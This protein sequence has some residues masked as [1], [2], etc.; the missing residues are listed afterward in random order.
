MSNHTHLV[1]FV[2]E[3]TAKAW[4]SSEVIERWHQL[5]KGTLLTQQFS[6]RENIPNYLM[7]S[8]LETVEVYRNRLMDISWFMRLLNQC[9]ATR[10]N[11]EV[12]C[13]G[14]FWEDH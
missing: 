3:A 10:A 1:L 9:I 5:F 12:N 4:S 7:A 6:G 14:H 11:Q 8:L 2:D 13:T